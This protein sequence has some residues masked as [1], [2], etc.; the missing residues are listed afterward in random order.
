M[1]IDFVQGGSP[2]NPV[3]GAVRAAVPHGARACF[4]SNATADDILMSSFVFDFDDILSRGSCKVKNHVVRGE[5]VCDERASS[6]CM[7]VMF[8][9]FEE[10]TFLSGNDNLM[11]SAKYSINLTCLKFS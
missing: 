11:C 9:L 3:S 2:A 6:Y 7:G 1:L 8:R 4:L 10:L 5:L